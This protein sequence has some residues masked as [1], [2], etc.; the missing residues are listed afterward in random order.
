[1]TTHNYIHKSL[2]VRSGF[3]SSKIKVNGATQSDYWSNSTYWKNLNE[4]DKNLKADLLKILFISSLTLLILYFDF[5]NFI[6]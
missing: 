1:M 2:F 6:S 3:L 4:I 5:S